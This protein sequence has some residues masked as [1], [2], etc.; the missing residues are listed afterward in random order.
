MNEEIDIV[1][2]WLN[3]TE[4]W[5]SQYKNYCENEDPC[6]IRDLNTIR[7]TIKSI[8]K[9]LPWVRYIW[10]IV[11]DEEQHNN[12]DWEELKNEKV[13]FIYHRDI[14]PQEFLPNF[15]SMLIEAYIHKIPELAENFIFSNDDIIFVKPIPKEFYIK[16]NKIVH[17][18]NTL[19]KRIDRFHN[20]YE[21]IINSTCK[22]IKK[23]TGEYIRA[24][25]FHMPSIHKKSLLEFIWSKSKDEIYNSF[26]ESRIRKHK[27]L[28]INDILQTLEE[29]YN[30]CEYDSFPQIKTSPIWLSDKTSK[31]DL[32]KLKNNNHIVC[33]NDGELLTNKHCNEIANYIKEV[34]NT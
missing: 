5:F 4:Q 34:F 14:L 25:D 15:N 30:M 28:S 31:E 29:K 26:T 9:N 6:R 2:P 18:K 7:P 22:F 21:Y 13:K 24:D 23:I 8:I 10:L 1:I 3:P 11:F 19:H 17:R 16:N 27:N 12:L 33:I 20:T 32:I